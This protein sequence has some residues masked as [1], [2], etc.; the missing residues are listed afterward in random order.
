MNQRLCLVISIHVR[1]GKRAEFE[2]FERRVQS[3]LANHGGRLEQRLL[4]AGGDEPDEIHVVS[5]PDEAALSAYRTDPGYTALAG[6]RSDAIRETSMLVTTVAPP[7]SAAPLDETLRIVGVDHVFLSVTDLPRS[8]KFYDGVMTALGFRKVEN[9][10]AGDRHAHYLNPSL[11]L[12]IRPARSDERADPHRAG[13]HHL[14]LQASDERG[15]D[16]AHARLTAL[17]VSATPP[18][19]YPEYN[20]DYYATFFEDPDG[21]RFEIVAWTRLR[22]SSRT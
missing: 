9:E 22:Q 21:I 17:G 15:V 1:D 2:D 4:G 19:I 16:E 12:T 20:S 3:I 7:F 5:F 14:C 10:L 13:L 8:E 6:A 11:Q 18:R